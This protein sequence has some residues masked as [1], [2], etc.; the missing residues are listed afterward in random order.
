MNRI[1]V[2]ALQWNLNKRLKLAASQR[3]YLLVVSKEIL[4]RRRSDNRYYPDV[5]FQG[6]VDFSSPYFLVAIKLDGK[7]SLWPESAAGL[8]LGN[9]PDFFVL[10]QV[11]QSTANPIYVRHI[12]LQKC[13]KRARRRNLDLATKN[14]FAT[15]LYPIPKCFREESFENPAHTTTH[16][17]IVRIIRA[18]K[19]TASAGRRGEW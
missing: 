15:R 16:L 11:L 18:L 19:E 3:S 6:Y 5:T 4:R 1:L 14:P 13:F 10:L 2:P 17:T 8:I 9:K 12:R 7:K